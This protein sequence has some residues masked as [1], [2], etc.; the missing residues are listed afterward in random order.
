M[1]EQKQFVDLFKKKFQETEK[2]KYLHLQIVAELS[3]ANK[4][5]EHKNPEHLAKLVQILKEYFFKVETWTNY[6]LFLFSHANYIFSHNEIKVLYKTRYL[7]LQKQ[8]KLKY[9]SQRY[10]DEFIISIINKFTRSGYLEDAKEALILYKTHGTRDYQLQ[11][12]LSNIYYRFVEAQ[13]EICLGNLD[14][15]TMM[16]HVLNSLFFIGDYPDKVNNF[17]LVTLDCIKKINQDAVVFFK[18]IELVDGM[19]KVIDVSE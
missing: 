9:E 10:V 12:Y 14:G 7:R 3:F 8:N 18:T 6:E 16:C 13:L 19:F 5:G 11:N 2:I 4:L 1:V 17:Y 15:L